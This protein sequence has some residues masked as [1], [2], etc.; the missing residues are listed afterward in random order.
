MHM[1][2]LELPPRGCMSLQTGQ[3]AAYIHV[4]T[5]IIYVVETLEDFN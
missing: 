4:Q 3:A 5:H 2:K 1:A